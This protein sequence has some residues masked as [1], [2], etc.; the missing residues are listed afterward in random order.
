MRTDFE[1]QQDVM[2]EIKWEPLL[3]ASEI[4]VAVN[5]GVVTLSGLVNTYT[6][7]LLA[8]KAAERVHGVKAVAEDIEVKILGTG[9]KKDS[10]I[11]ETALN[12][13]KWNSSILEEQIKI[14]V[15][16]GRLTL[17]GEVEWEFF[18][19]AAEKAVEN[20]VGVRSIVNNIKITSKIN[21]MDIKKKI[22]IAF[23]RNATIDTENINIETVN[24]KV[25]LTGKVSSWIERKEA[26]RAAW[27][28]PGVNSVENKLKVDSEMYVY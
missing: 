24:N 26:E 11:A 3:N 12:L 13:L 19:S 10:E 14:K 5:S 21:P 27:L 1:I 16:H 2:A 20:L 18:K 4:G 22:T 15:E 17:E 6:K 8:E 23:H 28:A 7:K 25:I 9:E